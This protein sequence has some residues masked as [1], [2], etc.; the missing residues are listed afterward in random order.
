MP[1]KTI[2]TFIQEIKLICFRAYSN[3]IYGLTIQSTIISYVLNF[4]ILGSHYIYHPLRDMASTNTSPF[5]WN[6]CTCYFWRALNNHQ[7]EVQDDSEEASMHALDELC[8]FPTYLSPNAQ[9][10]KF[11]LMNSNLKKKKVYLKKRGSFYALI[12]GEDN[13]SRLPHD[14][15]IPIKIDCIY[16]SFTRRYKMSIEWLFLTGKI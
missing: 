1:L 13:Q 5:G 9:I 11:S 3:R 2:C 4:I 14:P 6:Y 15:A 12:T 16:I 10:Q 8:L 7:Q